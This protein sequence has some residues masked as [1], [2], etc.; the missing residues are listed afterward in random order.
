MNYPIKF[1][2][3]HPRAALPSY[4]PKYKALGGLSYDDGKGTIGLGWFLM[5]IHDYTDPFS[6]AEVITH[7]TLHHIVRR[8][9]GGRACHQ[10]DVMIMWRSMFDSWRGYSNIRKIDLVRKEL[11]L[12][13]FNVPIDL[14]FEEDKK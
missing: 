2:K 12:N 6:I 4:V 14:L 1:F 3:P 7:E 13:R 5:S 10:L 8:F 9:E 11:P